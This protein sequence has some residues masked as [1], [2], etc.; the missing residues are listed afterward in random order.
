MTFGN[1]PIECSPFFTEIYDP[2]E[3]HIS[4]LP[5]EIIV[6]IENTLEIDTE[7]AG[8]APLE[9][10][11]TSPSGINGKNSTLGI[12]NVYFILLVPCK[13]DDT[14]TIKRVRFTPIE[15]GLHYLNVKYGSE[16]VPGRR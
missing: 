12:M 8:N 1:K 6:G 3:V 11:I 9:V 13:I 5:K 10:I 2:F 14:L 4:S 7:K 16:T 15:I